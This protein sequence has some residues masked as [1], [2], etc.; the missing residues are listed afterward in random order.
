MVDH[1]MALP[2]YIY[3]FTCDRYSGC[4]Y[5]FTIANNDI[6]RY[7]FLCFPEYSLEIFRSVYSKEELLDRRKLHIFY[8]TQYCHNTFKKQAKLHSP[9]QGMK[10]PVLLYFCHHWAYL[11]LK[12]SQRVYGHDVLYFIVYVFI[13]QT[14][15][16]I[17]HMLIFNWL[18]VVILLWIVYSDLCSLYLFIFDS[19]DVRERDVYILKSK[20]C[21]FSS[22]L[23]SYL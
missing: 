6:I 14:S 5:L 7:Y 2:Q 21:H 13:S 8:C 3:S 16:E 15:S 23:I 1:Y 12:E 18:F 20:H 22:L 10:I 17:E 9:Q 11:D 19:Q 4:F